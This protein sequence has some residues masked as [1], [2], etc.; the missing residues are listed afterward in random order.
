M[1]YFVWIC[2]SFPTNLHLMVRFVDIPSL[3]HIANVMS[4]LDCG[5]QKLD[6]RIELY[7]YDGH[8][9]ASCRSSP[10]GI[11][12]IGSPG[13]Y[14]SG[15]PSSAD[16]AASH[17]HHPK[18]I[19]SIMVYILN[20]AF[21]DYQ[22]NRLSANQFVEKTDAPAV[23][24]NSVNQTLGCVVERSHPGLLDELWQV[25]R[26]SIDL[27]NCD[28]YELAH[29][30]LEEPRLWSFYLFWHDKQNSKVLLF[31]CCSKSKFFHPS[32][33]S[34]SGTVNGFDSKSSQW[35]MVSSKDDLGAVS[36]SDYMSDGS[37]M[38]YP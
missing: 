10:N 33:S 12:P 38:H 21:P 22:F 8:L 16:R 7:V 2:L 32:S 23:V 19:Y 11:Q 30:A 15:S 6:A 14:P 1:C 18:D 36:S 20:D 5:D 27:S 28:I 13:I 29:D 25:L 24:V 35:S 9:S 31:S 4:H 37:D 17:L 26:Q 34:E 3:R